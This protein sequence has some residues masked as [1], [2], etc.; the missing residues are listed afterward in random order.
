MRQITVG[1][2]LPALLAGAKTV[3]RQAWKRAPG[4]MRAGQAVTVS[5]PGRT[6]V[7]T[8][9]LT[10]DPRLEP[11]GAT[12]DRGDD[13]EGWRWLSE[14]PEALGPSGGRT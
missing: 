6:P 3:T 13:V 5:G 11:L 9:R 1:W 2:T 10:A 7:A 12:P 4:W 8:I 14:H